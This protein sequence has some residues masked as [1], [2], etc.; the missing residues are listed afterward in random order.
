MAGNKLIL[1]TVSVLVML[2]LAACSPARTPAGAGQDPASALKTQVAEALASTAAVQTAVANALAATQA[3]LSSATPEFTLT[4]SLSPALQFTS[5]STPSIPMVSVS[6]ATNCRSGPTTVYDLLGILYV[7]EK[8]EVVGRSTYT[9]TMIIRLPSRPNVTC[10]L[11]AQNAKVAGDISRLPLFE[12]P[13]APS[14]AP[15]ALADFTVT[16]RSTITCGGKFEI[17]LKITNTGSVSWESNR[18]KVTDQDTSEEHT[19]SYDDFPNVSNGCAVAS[20]DLNL[21]PGETGAT[22]SDGFSANPAGHSFK[23]NIR[24]CSR[25]GLDGTCLDKTITF[26]P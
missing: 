21:A 26:T 20:D 18:I 17:K 19:S 6:V 16:Y 25:D 24:V 12:V 4:P 7:G 10:W 22:T 5:T 15:A 14:Q 11:W 8:A 3:V 9:D 2:Y 13:P 23:A 1:T